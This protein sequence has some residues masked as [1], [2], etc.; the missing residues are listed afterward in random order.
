MSLN[1]A[2]KQLGNPEEDYLNKLNKP[3]NSLASRAKYGKTFLARRKLDIK[4]IADVMSVSSSEELND[5]NFVGLVVRIQ[6]KLGFNK[7]DS[8]RGQDGI[9]GRNTLQK[10]EKWKTKQTVEAGRK[11]QQ[12]VSVKKEE[13]DSR[14]EDNQKAD[15]IL[16]TLEGGGELGV[17]LQSPTE[18]ACI[19]DSNA[20]RAT[21]A[22]PGARRIGDGGLSSGQVLVRIENQRGGLKGV[23]LAIIRVG[24]NDQCSADETMSNIARMIKICQEEGVPEVRILTRPPFVAENRS[25]GLRKRSA[26]Q[27]IAMFEKFGRPGDVRM[28]GTTKVGVIDIYGRMA[29]EE[30][31]LPSRFA[32]ENKKDQLHM[33]KDGYGEMLAIVAEE[34]GMPGMVK[35]IKGRKGV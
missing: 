13:E 22:M 25:M 29:D 19:G 3:G 15:D 27:S 16:A 9:F 2:E 11:E 31:N 23:K 5:R 10:Y 24:G 4:K 6:Q 8:A 30:G 35:W 7:V 20:K 26:A 33:S 14:A 34:V 12:V 32:N 28:F 17:E 21:W 18:I 1:V